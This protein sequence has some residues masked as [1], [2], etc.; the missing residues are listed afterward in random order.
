[1][2]LPRIW[3]WGLNALVAIAIITTITPAY[4]QSA[5]AAFRAAYENRYT[6]DEFP[7][8]QAE[9]SINYE[10]KLDQGIVKVKPDLSVEV[11]NI[12]DPEMRQFI[13][14]QLKMEIIHRRRV[15][16]EQIHGQNRFEQAQS[17]RR[18]LFRRNFELAGTN[19]DGALDIR[20]V[21]DSID[22]YTVKNNTI[23]QVNRTLGDV[24]VTVDTIGTT[25]TS[26][27]YLV[28]QFQT[29]YR[30][31]Q[32]DEVLQKE[33]V[34]DEHQ[35]IGGYYFLTS[36]DIRYAK[37]GDPADKRTADIRLDFNDFQPLK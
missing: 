14:N 22:A 32:T 10:G 3:S 6:W 4:A 11:I 23:T 29:T 35:K 9:V 21:G 2:R 8:Y 26:Q 12:D 33:D 27:G 28:S 36:R 37:A 7:G 16:F 25:Q 31:P 5:E 19:D 24:A 1:M 34:R 17:S 20:E 30:S 18:N 13:E 15:P